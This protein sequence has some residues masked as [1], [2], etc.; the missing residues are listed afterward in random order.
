[1]TPSSP[2]PMRLDKW[3]WAA[4][5]FKTRSLAQ[6][7]IEQG[8]ARVNDERVKTARMLRVGERVTLRIET[9]EREVIVLALSEQRGPAS[10]AQTLYQETGKSIAARE[11]AREQRRLYAEPAH[12]IV[13]RPTKR[14]RRQLDRTRGGAVS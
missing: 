11:A 6:D 13:G 3:L 2:N 4:R 8:R 14:D 1:M 7:A 5:F 9:Q 12:D 10:V